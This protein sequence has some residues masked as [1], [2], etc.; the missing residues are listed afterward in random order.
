MNVLDIVIHMVQ[1][2]TTK[3]RTPHIDIM[4]IK[5]SLTYIGIRKHEISS[6]TKFLFT[7]MSLKVFQH[8]ERETQSFYTDFS[9]RPKP[10][11]V[12]AANYWSSLDEPRKST[13]FFRGGNSTHWF[14]PNLS[15]RFQCVTSFTSPGPNFYLGYLFWHLWMT[16][17]LRAR[18]NTCT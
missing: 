4:F 9:I 12:P 14:F 1:K 13:F 11:A 2:Y 15:P 7:F 5:F 3:I 8:E 16:H 17:L 18:V 6:G 10:R